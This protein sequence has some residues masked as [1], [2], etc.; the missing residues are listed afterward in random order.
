MSRISKARR[1]AG[2]IGCIVFILIIGLF[3]GGGQ[4]LYTAAVNR[5]PL[6][7]SLADFNKQRPDRHW[8]KLTNCQGDLTQASY[9]YVGS[10]VTDVYVPLT[11]PDAAENEKVHV[12]LLDKSP[13]TQALM[14]KVM[15]AKTEAQQEAFVKENLAA[16]QA[17]KKPSTIEG[18]VQFGINLKDEDRNKIKGAD[19]NLVE[20]FVIIKEG[21][22]PSWVTGLAMLAGGILLSLLAFWRSRKVA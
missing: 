16:I 9:L 4:E 5:E 13:A 22:R 14:Q 6:E 18:M 10:S 7:M 11:V 21:E 8:L 2:R 15:D 3:W 17:Y 12:V 1:G 20:D 19:K